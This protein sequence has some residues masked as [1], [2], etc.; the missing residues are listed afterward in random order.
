VRAASVSGVFG[1]PATWKAKIKYHVIGGLV[2]PVKGGVGDPLQRWVDTWAWNDANEDSAAVRK[3]LNERNTKL[4][5]SSDFQIR[6]MV[7]QWATSS[8]YDEDDS[9]V[10]TLK[11]REAMGQRNDARREATQYLQ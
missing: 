6:S 7:N 3:A 9:S 11:A 1:G 10:T 4:W 8:G 5:L 2:T